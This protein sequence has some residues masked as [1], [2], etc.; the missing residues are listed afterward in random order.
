MAALEP[1]S[2]ASFSHAPANPGSG[3]RQ[4]AVSGNALDHTAIRVGHVDS[5][6]GFEVGAGA[7]HRHTLT[8][9]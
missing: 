8:T 6:Q 3:E 5:G 9:H 1:T 2:L 4:L 7:N